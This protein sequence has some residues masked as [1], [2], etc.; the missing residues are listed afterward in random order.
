VETFNW[1]GAGRGVAVV[2]QGAGSVTI[3][4]S[5]GS[6]TLQIGN[7]YPAGVNPR[8]VVVD[9]FNGDSNPDLAIV[10]SGAGPGTSGVSVLLGNGDGTFRPAKFYPAGTTSVALA[11]GIFNSDSNHD[12]VVANSGSDD[13]SI[14]LGNPDGSFQAPLNYSLNEPGITV[15]PTSVISAFLNNDPISDV[16]VLT[17][18]VKGYAVLI[19]LG[20]GKLQA[21]IHYTLD[22]PNFVNN[23]DRFSDTAVDLNGDKNF[24]LILANYSSNH[25]TVLL[26]AG[27]GTFPT[28]HT[29]AAGPSPTC[30]HYLDS[31]TDSNQNVVF[32]FAVSNDVVDGVVTVLRGNADGTLQAPPLYRSAFIPTSLAI[33]DLNHDGTPDIVAAGSSGGP[34]VGAGVTMLGNVVEFAGLAAGTFKPPVTW[35]TSGATS[36]ALGDFNGDGDLDL[37]STHPAPGSGHVS[38]W[39]GNGDGTFQTPTPFTAG[40]TPETVV[41]ADVN[42]DRKLDLVVGNQNSGNISVLLGLGDGTFLPAVNY[43]TPA[44]GTPDSLVVADFN[45][46]GKPDIAVAISGINAT[47][48]ALLLGNG[49]GTFQAAILMP[50]GFHSAGPL[51]IASGDFNGDG[52]FDLAVTD[53]TTVS[54][55]LGNATGAI[56]TPMPYTLIGA[57]AANAGMVAVADFDGDGNSDLAVTTRDGIFVLLGDGSGAFAPSA[58]YEPVLAGT[59]AIADIDGDSSP[60]IVIADSSEDS[61]STD[62]VAVLRNTKVVAPVPLTVD[63]IP[64]GLSFS[65]NVGNASGGGEFSTCEAAPCT[66]SAVWGK[67]FQ[68]YAPLTVPQS[69]GTRYA[70]DSFNDAGTSTLD[71][72][73]GNMIH[74]VLFPATQFTELIKYRQ[75][76]QLTVAVS[77]ANGGVATP[78]SSTYVDIGQHAAITATPSP[79]YAFTEW[80]G[81]AGNVASLSSPSTSVGMFQPVQLTANFTFTA[82]PCDVVPDQQINVADVQNIVNQALGLTPA[83]ADLNR[84]G[85]IDVADIGTLVGVA[86]GT[87]VCPQARPDVN[88]RD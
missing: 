87:G 23:N 47:L 46:D 68:V 15:S 7:T 18:S 1:N 56:P 58:N 80:T 78:A 71:F 4:S 85:R 53:G 36:I 33:G 17:P 27:D 16:V 65:A 3:L 57:G 8:Q 72:A 9:D 34:G 37:V 51:R 59:I 42:G 26:G 74:N 76:F 39:L 63:T 82:G 79:G 44:L 11:V 45:G 49:N 6:G 13:I 48:V 73:G 50:S 62:T 54:V 24:D 66:Y 14:L 20:D 35:T 77:P 88:P 40:T 41:V 83:A 10:D 61:I 5:N 60:D 19:G 69:Q 52:K 67:Y 21:P 32:D 38:V 55:L 29:Y 25:V 84:D 31:Y 75:Q 64:T 12:L 43:S 28:S 2:C 70:L 81:D 86:L 22:F 30:V